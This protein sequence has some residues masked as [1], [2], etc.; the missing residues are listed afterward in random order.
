MAICWPPSRTTAQAWPTNCYSNAV[1]T[2]LRIAALPC[3]KRN[4]LCVALN[5]NKMQA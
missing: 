2:A 5:L 3:Y 1:A 4:I